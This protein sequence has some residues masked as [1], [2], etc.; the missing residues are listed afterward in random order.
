MSSFED[1]LRKVKRDQEDK[2]AKERRL[3]E[4]RI[5]AEEELS[6][7]R[8]RQLLDLLAYASAELQPLLAAVNTAYCEGKGS[9]SIGAMELIQKQV[10]MHRGLFRTT[11]TTNETR[12]PAAFVRLGWGA[13]GDW[14]TGQYGWGVYGGQA[15]GL[16]VTAENIYL[17]AG[18]NPEEVVRSL[19]EEYAS[20]ICSRANPRWRDEVRDAILSALSKGWGKYRGQWDNTPS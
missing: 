12:A 17:C 7:Q 15:L 9:V 8:E 14:P 5:R 16:L 10:Q 6:R 4:D 18:G 11:S 2:A 13:W 3:E 20:L 1:D 19:H